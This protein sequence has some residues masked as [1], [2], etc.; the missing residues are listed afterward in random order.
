MKNKKIKE[1]T[2][3]GL[4]LK[5]MKSYQKKAKGTKKWYWKGRMD[6][7]KGSLRYSNYLEKLKNK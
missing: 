4:T 7:L 5:Q 2:S 6:G 3:N 1:P